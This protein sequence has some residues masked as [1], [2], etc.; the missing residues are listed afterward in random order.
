MESTVFFAKDALE[1]DYYGSDDDVDVAE[2]CSFYWEKE[3]K[4]YFADIDNIA[5]GYGDD[6]IYYL[7]PFCSCI[8]FSFE[9]MK[10]SGSKYRENYLFTIKKLGIA[11]QKRIK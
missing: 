4:F 9:D 6:D 8:E 10:K 11:L 3:D 7:V 1:M 5:N 2:H